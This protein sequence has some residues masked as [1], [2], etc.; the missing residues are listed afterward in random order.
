MYVPIQIIL[1]V[2][3]M[4][5][6]AW[7]RRAPLIFSS[8]QESWSKA[9]QAARGLATVFS[10][11]FFSFFSNNLVSIVSINNRSI[12]QNAPPNRCLGTPL[13]QVL[14]IL[15]LHFLILYLISLNFSR[16]FLIASFGFGSGCPGLREILLI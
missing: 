13:L 2:R 6:G 3:D 4:P 9:S 16:P 7:G 5:M 12:G 11:T 10:G 14:I 8:L 1:Q 15:P